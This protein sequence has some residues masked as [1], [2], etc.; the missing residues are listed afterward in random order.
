M[1]SFILSMAFLILGYFIYGRFVERVFGAKR[2][3]T[4][5]AYTMQDG[6]DYIP[7]PWW[8]AFLIQFL[9]IAA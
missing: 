5:P 3:N 6:I 9:N 8:K 1:F 4:T 7:M 2:D